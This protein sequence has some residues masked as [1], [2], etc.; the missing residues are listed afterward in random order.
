MISL[1][2]NYYYP[3]H[4]D[5]FYPLHDNYPYDRFPGQIIFF[6]TFPSP[7]KT[8]CPQGVGGGK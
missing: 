6:L 5:Y 4:D 8:P 2:D 7:S 3:L 1:H